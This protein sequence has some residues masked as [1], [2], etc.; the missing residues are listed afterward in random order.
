MQ[1]EADESPAGGR[2]ETRLEAVE[3]PAIFHISRL[4]LTVRDGRSKILRR[5]MLFRS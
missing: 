5:A 4:L 2:I 3:R 1:I